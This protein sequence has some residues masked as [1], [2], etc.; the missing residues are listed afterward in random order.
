MA[1]PTFMPATVFAKRKKEVWD[2]PD[3]NP[4]AASAP[5]STQIYNKANQD[6]FKAFGVYIKKN[7]ESFLDK[8]STPEGMTDEVLNSSN[9]SGV[10]GM[11]G[12]MIGKNALTFNTADAIR[13]EELKAQGYNAREIWDKTQNRI[14]N[15]GIR[16][17]IDDSVMK[18]KNPFQE[19]NLNKEFIIDDDGISVTHLSKLI[20]HPEL[21]KAYPNLKKTTIRVDPSY[22]KGE[23]SYSPSDDVITIGLTPD[24][25]VD[26]QSLL[27]EIQHA[28]QA[29]EGWQGGGSPDQF[30]GRVIVLPNGQMK[31]VN[32]FTEYQ[33]LAG[34]WEARQTQLREKLTAEQRAKTFPDDT[35]AKFD[36]PSGALNVHDPD[37]VLHK[38]RPKNK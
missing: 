15:T 16:Q 21:F 2:T 23:A 11:L 18:I 17:E 25:K 3:F 5:T 27:H 6:S 37:Y 19:G 12:T 33:T 10:G 29:R 24:D 8:I 34:E 20:D 32:N 38:M 28:I 14:W 7:V 9:L 35:S 36:Y 4:H 1:D 30:G 22:S 13:A 31:K 26:T